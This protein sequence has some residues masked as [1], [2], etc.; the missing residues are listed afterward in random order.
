MDSR[1]D[2]YQ[3]FDIEEFQRS[4]KNANLYKEVY[5]NYGDLEDLPVSENINEIDIENLKSLVGSR[6][7][8]KKE[9]LDNNDDNVDDSAINYSYEE[10]VH[11][12]NTLLEKAKEEN[13]KIKKEEPISRNV[14]NYLANLESDKNTKEILLNYD[15]ESD[16]DLPIVKG[17]KYSTSEFHFDDKVVNTS[18][19]SLDIL[20]DLKPTG[21]TGINEVVKI[22]DIDEEEEKE[23]YSGKLEFSKADF[24]INSNEESDEE[25]FVEE[26]D[27]VFL[28]VILIIIGLASM[29][30][31]LYFI[32]KEYTNIF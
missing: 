29:F 4:K 24:V 32:L 3:E 20:S 7:S 9:H 22:D 19:L 31:A 13:A 8:R 14:P 16:D 26:N 10:K 12:I 5:G 30:T 21:N 11:D 18:S 1:M 15:G 17:I 25:L 27:H 6:V 2:K 28:K 23:F